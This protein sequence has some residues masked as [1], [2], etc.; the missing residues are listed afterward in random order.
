MQRLSSKA[1][2]EL[3]RSP[4][5]MTSRPALLSSREVISPASSNS[6]RKN[7]F[8][9]MV[10][11]TVSPETS[12]ASRDESLECRYVRKPSGGAERA[13]RTRLPTHQA[14]GGC[15]ASRVGL[16]AACR[17]ATPSPPGLR[18][19]KAR[20]ENRHGVRSASGVNALKPS[21]T[22]RSPMPPMARSRCSRRRRPGRWRSQE[23]CRGTG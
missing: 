10:S 12:P 15:S 5:A 9:S 14:A 1:S 16:P 21:R 7:W 22:P 8:S 4:A 23:G 19:R 6:I 20:V 18:A 3:P 2:S 11:V 13:T 17:P